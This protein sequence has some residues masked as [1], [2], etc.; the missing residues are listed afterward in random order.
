MV[1]LIVK[2]MPSSLDVD[3]NELKTK[4]Q[5]KMEANGAKNISFEEKPIAFGL[6]ALF[7]KM[8]LPEDKGTD[9]VEA[10]LSKIDGVSSI[11]LE[12]YRR[13]FG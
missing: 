11:T 5:E 7:M 12:D 2:I 13:A 3:L 9:L 6:K 10:E 1:A 4:S 8:A